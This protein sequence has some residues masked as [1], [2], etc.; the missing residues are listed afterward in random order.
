MVELIARSPCKDLLP[1]T[2]GTVTATEVDPGPA[3]LILPRGK[4]PKTVNG[5][6]PPAPGRMTARGAARLLWF[7]HGQYLLLGEA[8]DPGLS[9]DAALVD[10]SDAWAMVRLDGAGAEAVL[11]RLIPLD[12]RAS[13]FPPGHTARTEIAHM[14]GSVTRLGGGAFLLCVFRSMAA[15]LVHDLQ[16]AMQALDARP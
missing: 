11:A 3:T 14:A 5:L 2:I 10:H 12:L 1:I 6:E 16:T 13:A 9:A 15:T 8:P 4:G 7:G